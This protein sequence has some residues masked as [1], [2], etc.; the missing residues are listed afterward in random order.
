MAFIS[1]CNWPLL[2]LVVLYVVK[3]LIRHADTNDEQ[4]V[5]GWQ[6]SLKFLLSMHFQWQ[7]SLTA[8]EG[9]PSCPAGFRS[10]ATFTSRLGFNHSAW[11]K[12]QRSSPL[13]KR[14]KGW[15]V[16]SHTRQID[17]L[18][19][20]QGTVIYTASPVGFRIHTDLYFTMKRTFPTT[21]FKGMIVITQP[22]SCGQFCP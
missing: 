4:K 22:F 17:A 10:C 7:W 15:L 5:I 21:L 3:N 16:I 9:A 14:I 6:S 1:V 11:C 20:R 19:F 2:W 18:Y 13:I 8:T 12:L